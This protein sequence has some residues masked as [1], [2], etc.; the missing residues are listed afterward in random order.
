MSLLS[1]TLN[2]FVPSEGD[3]SGAQTGLQLAVNNP[4]IAQSLIDNPSLLSTALTA[5]K[6]TASG[7]PDPTKNYAGMYIILG[8][9][10][11]LGVI[12]TL[13]LKR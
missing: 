7:T 11:V 10:F 1:D 9:V 6:L 3:I 4:G 5:S 2:S 12:V 8:A 13:I